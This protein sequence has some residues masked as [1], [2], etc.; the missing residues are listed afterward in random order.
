M[1]MLGRTCLNVLDR[2]ASVV[3]DDNVGCQLFAMV[4]D[5]A[6]QGNFEV[7]FALRESETLAHKRARETAATGRGGVLQLRTS[8]LEADYNL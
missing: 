1:L 3:T 2:L 4:V 8:N 6:V 5:L 7:E